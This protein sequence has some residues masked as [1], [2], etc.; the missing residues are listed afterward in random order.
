MTAAAPLLDIRD[1]T[2]PYGG[3][4]PLR[5]R[6]LRMAEGERMAIG[7]LDAGAA[8]TLIHLMTGAALPDTGEVIVAGLN[9]RDIATD[10]AWLA[11]LDRFGIVTE[12]AVLIDKISVQSNLALPMTL[13]I[14]PMADAV[15]AEV[16][17]LAEA[18]G[19]A[20]DMLARPV[21]ALGAGDRLRLHLARAL[22]QGPSLLILEHP[23]AALDQAA[24]AALGRAVR[25]V[26]TARGLAC[27]ALTNDDVF[28]RASE[29]TR[30]RLDQS[31]GQLSRRWPW[32]K[33]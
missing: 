32:Q 21:T 8:E 29:L 13:S 10:T 25:D 7:G 24:S 4:E 15:M 6:A 30:C 18:V 2:K 16:R 19:L 3:P 23:T 27:L 33:I 26:T 1:V 5:L 12:R 9:T 11:S 14:E 31:T 28:A 17:T 20:S 22:A